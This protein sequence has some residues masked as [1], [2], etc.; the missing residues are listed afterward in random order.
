[1]NDIPKSEN[2]LLQFSE[3][4]VIGATFVQ[5]AVICYSNYVVNNKQQVRAALANSTTDAKDWIAMAESFV[6]LAPKQID[7]ELY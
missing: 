4:D 5:Q 1:M 3:A 2:Q 7:P 6:K